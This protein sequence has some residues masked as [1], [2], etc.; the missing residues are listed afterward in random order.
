MELMEEMSVNWKQ[1]GKRAGTSPTKLESFESQYQFNNKA[2][3]GAAIKAWVQT[4]SKEVCDF[5]HHH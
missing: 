2:C 3:M 1:W 5:C 4:G